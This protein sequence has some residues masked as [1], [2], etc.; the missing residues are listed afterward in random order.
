MEP[1]EVDQVERR[2]PRRTIL[3]N[4][5]VLSAYFLSEVNELQNLGY[6]DR[7]FWSNHERVTVLLRCFMMLYGYTENPVISGLKAYQEADGSRSASNTA[8]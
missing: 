5:R 8:R 4:L 6:A 7:K 2:M 3:V 1:C